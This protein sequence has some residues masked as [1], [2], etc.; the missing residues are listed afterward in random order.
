MQGAVQGVL[1]YRVREWW[2]HPSPTCCWDCWC[3]GTHPH[4]AP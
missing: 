4:V 2:Q 3:I 1:D